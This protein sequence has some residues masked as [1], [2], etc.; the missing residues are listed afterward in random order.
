MITTFTLVSPPTR[1]DVLGQIRDDL[2]FLQEN[3]GR[4][5]IYTL[6]KLA[7]MIN[8][9]MGTKWDAHYVGRFIRGEAKAKKPAFYKLCKLQRGILEE[10]QKIEMAY[11][12]MFRWPSQENV[13]SK[14]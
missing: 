7:D 13:P 9:I 3:V 6:Q 4:D 10:R 8:R 14:N 5:G 11:S 2:K 12:R 1:E